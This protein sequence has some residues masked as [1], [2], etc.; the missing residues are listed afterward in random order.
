MEKLKKPSIETL[1]K[2][3]F[4]LRIE[5]KIKTMPNILRKYDTFDG[6]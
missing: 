2:E 1:D 5:Y 6:Q 3:D 4:M